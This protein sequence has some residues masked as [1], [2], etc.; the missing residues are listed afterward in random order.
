[1]RNPMLIPISR[2]CLRIGCLAACLLQAGQADAA[3]QRLSLPNL[4]Q[5]VSAPTDLW[6]EIAGA[7]PEGPSYEF[8]S[9]LLP[10]LRY[11]N[12]DFRYYPIVLSAPR[13]ETKARLI[14]N[15]SALNA[16]GGT[17]SWNDAALPVTF[18]VG[19]DELRFGEYPD[20]VLGVSYESG[21]LPITR[22][23]YQHGLATYRQEA[24]ASVDPNLAAHGVVFLEFSLVDGAIGSVVADPD[25]REPFLS[26][27]GAVRYQDGRVAIW[28]DENW[29]WTRERLV[30]R[31][32]PR[33]K[34]RLAIATVPA[35][36]EKVPLQGDAFQ[37]ERKAAVQA[38]EGVV[39]S[40]MQLQVP[41]PVV[42]NAW[43]SLIA[44][45]FALINQNRM[46][47]SAGNQYDKLYQAEGCDAVE[48]LVLW[49]FLDETP[50]LITS[51]MKFTRKGLEYHQA[52]HKLQLLANYYW[53][54]GDR[55]FIE[56]HSDYWRK[57]LNLVLRG[58]TNQHGLFPREQY[59]G[60]VATPVYSLNSNAKAWRAL[61]DFAAVL[62]EIGD[63]EGGARLRETAA[64]FRERILKAVRDSQDPSTKPPF[65]PIA[66]FGEE[67]AYPIITE[68]KIGSYWNL[69]ANYI[70]GARVFGPGAPEEDWILRYVEQHGGL[71]MG[72]IRSRP[73]PTFWTGEHS[74]NPLY[75]TRRV[76]TLLERDEVEAVIVS[77]YGMLAQGFT[78]E[79]F[80]S[81]EGASL[82]PLD[83][84]G[85]LFYC[86][87]NS[88]GNAHFLT[89]LRQMLVQD[90]DL[91]DDGRPETLRLF[92]ATPRRWL[93]DASVVAMEN[94]PTSF[95]AAR[96]RMESRLSENVITAEV[97][98]P[99]WRVPERVFIR[100]R[101]PQEWEAVSASA[102]G[103]E[104]TVDERGTVELS[105]LDGTVQ[106]RWKVRKR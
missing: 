2:N 27:N 86:P 40:G 85:R 49:G 45:T 55:E 32:R 88:A 76:L 71:C 73:N 106:V 91:N 16:A 63:S 94:A 15:G 84:R 48:A 104:R 74:I 6:G 42:Q 18:R 60:D 30:A 82:T 35:G 11:V 12:A 34:A 1:M 33:T 57:E 62:E 13:S 66:L 99:T 50:D 59:C 70:L 5:V 25:P 61:R 53:R 23:D 54:T 101:L 96:A 105:G 28:H 52:G 67:Q 17:R 83:E 90:L 14:S 4:E 39:G 9:G 56:G 51:Q 22:I 46:H 64:E 38:W 87:P 77:F 47:Y 3:E 10:P 89:M 24:F 20:R 93:L 8:F 95:G 68:T 78:R 31:L 97:A 79:T 44:G 21:W 69:M 103:E 37:A 65:I 29:R 7:Q 36:V 72:Q 100:A 80:I 92:F 19:P 102:N 26:T 81:G 75:G 58:R 41:E 98:M 43:R